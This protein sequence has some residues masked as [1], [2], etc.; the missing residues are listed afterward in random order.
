M[1]RYRRVSLVEREAVS[2]LLAAGSS[3]RVAGQVLGRAPS[4][5]EQSRLINGRSA[6][7]TGFASPAAAFTAVVQHFG[8]GLTVIAAD[9]NV[10]MNKRVDTL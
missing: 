7:S 3:L 2:R 5:I 10:E 1:A 4:P 9:Q 8:M 6:G